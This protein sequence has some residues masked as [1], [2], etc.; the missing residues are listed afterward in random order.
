MG[1]STVDDETSVVLVSHFVTGAPQ[2]IADVSPARP[3]DRVLDAAKRCCERWGMAKVT[4]DDI[5]SEAG[6]SR[7]TLYR[8]FPGGRDVLFDALRAR[9]T[10][11]F[12][13]ELDAHVQAASDYEDL[14]VRVLVEATQQLRADEHLQVMLASEPGEVVLRLG[15]ED[16]PRFFEV[17]TAFL[18]PRVAPHIGEARAGA[19]AEWLVRVTLSYFLTPSAHADLGAPESAEAF[20]RHFVLPAFPSQPGPGLPCPTQS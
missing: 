9:E 13:A 2:A 17:A 20:V 10:A 19:L 18:T 5:V 12:F 15:F 4:V 14:L 1:A 7:A 3:E 11:E 8:L 16:L 6:V